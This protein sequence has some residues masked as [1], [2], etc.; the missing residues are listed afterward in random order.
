MRQLVG[1]CMAGLGLLFATPARA[2]L[3]VV[4]S[5][6]SA[7]VL[8]GLVEGHG[9][10]QSAYWA[11]TTGSTTGYGEIVPKDDWGRLIAAG[12]MALS[13]LLISPTITALIV[14]GILPTPHLYSDAEQGRDQAADRYQIAMLE[15][16]CDRLG[17]ADDRLLL[18]RQEWE[19]AT[20]AVTKEK[21]L[22]RS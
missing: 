15:A 12:L 7:A 9:P 8:F 16:L 13:W 10:I 17:L 14:G 20:E 1:Q 19:T 3:L 4:G 5:L 22:A 21:E 6:G 18:A 11:V 2:A